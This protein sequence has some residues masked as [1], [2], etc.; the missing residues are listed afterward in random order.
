MNH[1][2]GL[3]GILVTGFLGYGYAGNDDADEQ[4]NFQ[5]ADTLTW[6][7]RYA[8]DQDRGRVSLQHDDVV[9]RA[10][11]GLLLVQRTIH[12]ERLCRFLLAAPNQVVVANGPAVIDM[13]A[14]NYNFFIQDD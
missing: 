9:G 7:S 6:V 2:P 12:F 1:V 10:I 11:P 13:R 8:L 5:L 3:P 4:N 14:S